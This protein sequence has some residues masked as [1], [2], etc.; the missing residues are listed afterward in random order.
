STGSA[1]TVVWIHP[2][3]GGIDCYRTIARLS[4]FRSV[5][6]ESPALS[7]EAYSPSS[8]AQMAQHYLQFLQSGVK[9]PLILAGWS[10]GGLLALEMAEQLRLRGRA[11]SNV[12]LIDCYPP[13]ETL[14]QTLG[15]I[16]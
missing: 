13:S 12:I 7:S 16:S 10:L 15:M 11:V 6:V 8:L 9:G 3:G 2:V 14:A 1:P 5:A 4:A